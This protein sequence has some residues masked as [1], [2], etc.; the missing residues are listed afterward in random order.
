MRE[1]VCPL[2]LLGAVTLGAVTPCSAQRVELT[3]FMGAYLPNANFDGVAR[4]QICIPPVGCYLNLGESAQQE[5][6]VLGGVRVTA[7]VG[8]QVAVEVSVG[9]AASGIVTRGS[10]N[11]EDAWP[12]SCNSGICT[13]NICTFASSAAGSVTTG[14]AQVLVA[15]TPSATGHP[16][17]FLAAGGGFVSHDIEVSESARTDWGPAFGVGVRLPVTSM[18]TPRAEVQLTSFGGEGTDYTL[19]LGLSVALSGGTPS[20]RE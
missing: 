11:T 10:C 14:T 5:N 19:T 9:Y 17:W 4:G 2:L 15:L 20:A 13:S 18:L 3:P 7:W 6:A 16:S 8:Q 12:L 1:T